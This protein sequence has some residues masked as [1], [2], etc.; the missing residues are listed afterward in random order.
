VNAKE[1]AELEKHLTPEELAELHELIAADIEQVVWRPLPGPQSVAY[2]SQADV[3]GFGGAAG[4][5]K[6]DLACGKGLTQ[7]QRIAVFRREGT[8]LTGIV[9]RLTELLGSRDGY[10]GQDR[11]WR[12]PGK[13]FE[14]CSVPNLG[15]EKKYQGR[16]KDL[17]VLD[18]A[19]N[20]LEAQVRFLMGWVRSTTP[21]QKCQTLMCFNP[22]TSAE[23]RWIV[24]FFAPWIDKRF[25]GK[26]ALPGEIRYVGVVPGEN[27]VSRDIWVDGPEQFVIVNGE[28]VFDFDPLEYEPQEI[29]TPQSRTFIPSRISDNPYLSGTGYMSVLQALPEPLRSQMLFGSFE[30]GMQDDPWQ[31]IPTA[32]IEAAQ[33]RWTDRSPKGPMDSIGVDV[34]RGGKDQ[35]VIAP[36]H[37]NWYDKLVEI[38]GKETPSGQHVVGQVVAVRRNSAPVHIDVIGVGASPYDLMREAN[39]QVIGVN[40]AEAS[41]ATDKSGRLRF[42]NQR[43]QLWWQLREALDPENDTGIMLPPETVNPGLLADL[44]APMWSLQGMKV[45]VESRDE[46]VKRIGRSPDKASALILAQLDTPNLAKIQKAK[47]ASREAILDWDPLRGF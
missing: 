11:I 42:M 13:Q 20:F 46:I 40:V 7:H 29:V 41:T 15:D 38:P 4:G 21:G 39:I 35:T 26:R 2:Y 33:A 28:P 22:P 12:L 47:G 14:L 18:E 30:A 6:T 10:N 8:E 16:P 23:G 9:D 17:L 5:G 1:I 43:S 32:W 37:G 34:A 36:R 3:I 19:A 25:N 24:S 27:G 45:C 44:A 31:V